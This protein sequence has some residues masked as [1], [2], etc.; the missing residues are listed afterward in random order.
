VRRLAILG[1]AIAAGLILLPGAA[2]SSFDAVRSWLAPQSAEC[3]WDREFHAARARLGEDD[4][5]DPWTVVYLPE[6]LALTNLDR[7]S[8]RFSPVV[9]CRSIDAVVR[10]EH[11]H[12]RQGWFYGG[13]AQVFAAYGGGS[14]ARDFHEA[15][16]DCGA[17]LLD[18]RNVPPTWAYCD[19]PAVRVEARRL[20]DYQP[21]GG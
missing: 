11:M 2:S 1:V 18:D 13:K 7:Q 5:G 19:V 3:D 8:V 10:H 9:P 15:V 4:P 16:A 17:R 6:D 21:E 14:R 12:Q 20:L